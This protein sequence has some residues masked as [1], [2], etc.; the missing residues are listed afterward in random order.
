MCV[1]IYVCSCTVSNRSFSLGLCVLV[2]HFYLKSTGTDLLPHNAAVWTDFALALG[3][4]VWFNIV[5]LMDKLEWGLIQ[6]RTPSQ[7]SSQHTNELGWMGTTLWEKK[8]QSTLAV[9]S[10]C[11]RFVL[12]KSWIYWEVRR[13]ER[14][15]VWSVWSDCAPHAEL[16]WV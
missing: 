6:P 11:E 13:C 14:E 15:P 12:N 16:H 2:N 5:V 1:Y 10:L 4:T 9:A 3:F 7:C 8:T